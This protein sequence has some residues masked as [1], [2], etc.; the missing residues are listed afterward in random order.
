VYISAIWRF[1]GRMIYWRLQ[2]GQAGSRTVARKYSY[3]PSADT[4][5][6]VTNVVRDIAREYGPSP[7]AGRSMVI[8]GPDKH[9]F[10]VALL[11]LCAFPT[12]R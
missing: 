2:A 9:R 7:G 4:I 6:E 5:V 12:V 1:V 11:S 10:R 3:R 8:E